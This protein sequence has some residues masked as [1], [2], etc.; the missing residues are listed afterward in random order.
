MQTA[1]GILI[2]IL[3]LGIVIFIHELGHFLAARRAGIFVEEFA[4]GMGPKLISV[5][6]KKKNRDGET[7][8]F[9]LRAFPVGGFCKM[10]GQDDNL[11]DDPEALNNKSIPARALVMAGGSLMNFL[12]AFVIFFILVMISGVPTGETEVFVRN[13]IENRPAFAAGLRTD[14]II[15][16][17]NGVKIETPRDVVDLVVASEGAP[18]DMSVSRGEEQHSFSITPVLS[19]N[20]EIDDYVY[21]IGFTPSLR[22]QF[23]QASILDGIVTSGKMIPMYVTELLNLLSRLIAGEQIADGEGL[24][25]PI[26]MG[27][28]ITMIYQETIKRSFGEMLFAMVSFT[29]VINLALGVMNL[30]PIPA[31]DG[32]RLVFLGIEAIR[33]K[34]VPPEKEALVHMIGL[35]SLLMLAVFIAYRDTLWLFALLFNDYPG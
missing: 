8:L 10:R 33:K 5:N 35:V 31:L 22:F 32:A 7:T 1:I 26:R 23:A 6:G 18:I 14:D 28:E 25:G 12:L 27:G 20:N 21:M 9:S 34:P 29:A 13:V 4:L 17:I 11:P 30:F 3:I 15:T 24:M 2:F 19:W 16:H